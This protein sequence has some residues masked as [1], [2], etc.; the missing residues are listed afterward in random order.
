MDPDTEDSQLIYEVTTGPMH[1]YV[2]NK[3]QPGRLA[4][5]FTQGVFLGTYNGETCS[6]AALP[7]FCHGHFLLLFY[8]WNFSCL[9]TQLARFTFS[10]FLPVTSSPCLLPLSCLFVC[11]I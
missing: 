7:Y 3:L 4:A 6:N 9:A 10:E 5:T 8:K 2:E 1:G 11:F